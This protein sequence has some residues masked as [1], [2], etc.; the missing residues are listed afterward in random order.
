MATRIPPSADQVVLGSTQLRISGLAVWPAPGTPLPTPDGPR[1]GDPRCEEG[2]PAVS[3][4]HALVVTGRLQRP[5][6][7]GCPFN[8]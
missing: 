5:E 6:P 4:R 3:R 8:V 7:A 2:P 1:R